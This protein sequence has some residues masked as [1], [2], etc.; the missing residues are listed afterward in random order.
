MSVSLLQ[1]CSALIISIAGII[2]LTRYL[3]LHAFFSLL[4]SSIVFGLL[5]GKSFLE[6]L[7]SMQSGFGSLLQQIGLLV[8]FGSC[9]GMMMEKTGAMEVIG[10]RIIQ[11][12][13]VRY[14]VLA[15]TTIGIIVGIPVFCDSGFIIL[16]RLISSMA[17][18][19]T[20]NS[21]QLSLAL[22]SGL[23]TSHVL[24]PPT[25]GPLAAAANLNF[26]EHISTLIL[27]SIVAAIPVALVSYFFS[28]R[29]GHSI[30]ADQVIHEIKNEQQK[31]SAR[32]AFLPLLLPILLIASASIPSII[33]FHEN[34]ISLLR[35]IGHPVVALMIGLIIS[36]LLINKKNTKEMPSWISTALKDA[37][38]ILLITGAGGAF[39][40]VIKTSGIDVILKDY[41]SNS[42]SQGIFFILIA[43]VIAALL[44]T[45]QGSSTSAIIITSSLLAPLAAAAGF[46]SP[47]QLS[48]LVVAIGGGAMT[49]SHAN[50]SYF[51]VVSQFGGISS[52]DAFRSFTLLTLAQ[53]LTALLT[54]IFLFQFV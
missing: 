26:S 13:G 27:I 42:S 29:L 52:R 51:W 21:A 3:N 48:V 16:S 44:K 8:A 53:G 31:I 32:K 30:K 38:I 25:P 10:H 1:V 39:G 18:Q 41:V 11:F 46:V 7:T 40:A 24:V 22:S 50:D 6:T 36:I 5:V 33:P 35:T 47:A 15:M 34:I 12:F 54:S 49:V 14:S 28:L 20:A 23:Y 19:S 4:I 9:L 37:G 43:F 45:A 2:V 17:A